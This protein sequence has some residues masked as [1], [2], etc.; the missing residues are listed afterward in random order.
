MTA[1][2]QV[3][4][5]A[6]PSDAVC[7]VTGATDRQVVMVSRLGGSGQAVVGISP[8]AVAAE[9]GSLLAGLGHPPAVNGDDWWDDLGVAYG[10][11]CPDG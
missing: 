1:L 10:G 3:S 9:I 6:I 7:R 5:D 4:S 11:G 2:S 8:V